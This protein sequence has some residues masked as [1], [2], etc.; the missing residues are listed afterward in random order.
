VPRLDTER[1]TM[2]YPLL[3]AARNVWFLVT[4]DGKAEA[5]KRVLEGTDDVHDAPARGI[6]PVDGLVDWWLDRAAAAR[7]SSAVATII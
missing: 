2:T 7:L 6:V 5:V 3:N 1:I 4:G